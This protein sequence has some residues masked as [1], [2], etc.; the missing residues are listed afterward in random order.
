[1]HRAFASSSVPPGGALGLRGV[2]P[3]RSSFPT[4]GDRKPG[5]VSDVSGCTGAVKPHE[6]LQTETGLQREILAER[7]EAELPLQAN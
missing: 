7:Q 4:R 2:M 6:N 3:H 1:M 5:E